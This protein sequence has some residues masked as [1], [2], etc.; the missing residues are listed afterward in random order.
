MGEGMELTDLLKFG[1]AGVVGLVSGQMFLKRQERINN[2]VEMEKP[3]VVNIIEADE[4]RKQA[5]EKGKVVF[6]R[7][8][9][10]KSFPYCDGSH[11]KHNT[12][13]GDNVG[14]LIVKAE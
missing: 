14:P 4:F 3:K 5:G 10:S 2:R 1:V 12:E 7:C 11:N 6:C 8:W 9:K 13:V